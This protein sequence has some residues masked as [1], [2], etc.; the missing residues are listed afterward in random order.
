MIDSLEATVYLE[1]F[2]CQV[3]S[4]ICH[5]DGATYVLWI[6]NHNIKVK[7]LVLNINI[8]IMKAENNFPYRALEV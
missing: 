5:S 3:G 7:L 8:T 1:G 2:G 6:C 4:L